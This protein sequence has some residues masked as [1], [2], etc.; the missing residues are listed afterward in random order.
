[1]I[2]LLKITLILMENLNP[3]T[4]SVMNSEL[5]HFNELHFK[6]VDPRKLDLMQK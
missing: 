1:M 5:M 3:G 2:I 4:D 6:V